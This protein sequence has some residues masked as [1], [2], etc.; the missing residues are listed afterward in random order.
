MHEFAFECRYR[1]GC[2]CKKINV[3]R[4]EFPSPSGPKRLLLPLADDAFAASIASRDQRRCISYLMVWSP[5]SV[6]QMGE[7]IQSHLEERG[8]SNLVVRSGE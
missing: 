7:C 2:D 3:H 8:M 1:Y 5:H 4:P 6:Q